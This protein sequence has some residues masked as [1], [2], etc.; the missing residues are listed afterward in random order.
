MARPKCECTD[1]IEKVVAR[2]PAEILDWLTDLRK[3]AGWCHFARRA[4]NEALELKQKWDGPIKPEQL[5]EH[6]QAVTRAKAVLELIQ[7]LDQDIASLQESLQKG[8]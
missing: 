8:A 3:S 6:N 1:Y 2:N 5:D 7:S 4:W